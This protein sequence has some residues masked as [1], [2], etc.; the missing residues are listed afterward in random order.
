SGASLHI[1]GAVVKTAP[2]SRQS[3][4]QFLIHS[5][6]PQPYEPN[7]AIFLPLSL[8]LQ[9]SNIGANSSSSSSSSPIEGHPKATASNSSILSA[10]KSAAVNSSVSAPAA[11]AP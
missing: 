2:A 7:K 1:T 9:S 8:A 5:P 11:F 4:S 6:S 3:F 10:L